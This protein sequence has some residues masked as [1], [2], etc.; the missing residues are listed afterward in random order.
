[1]G[2]V[3]LI[4]IT[5][6]ANPRL[7]LPIRALNSV[8]APLVRRLNG[9]DPDDLLDAARRR[10]GLENYGNDSFLEPYRVLLRALEEEASLSALGRIATRGLI[11]QLLSNRLLIEDLIA[12]NPEIEEEKVERPIVIAGLPR[13]GTT[14]LLN[15]LAQD[16]ELRTLPY[17]ESLEPVPSGAARGGLTDLDSRLERCRRDIDRLDRM[18]PLFRMMHEFEVDGPHEEIQL[19]A[20]QFSTQLFEA[21]YRVPSYSEWLQQSDQTVAYAYTKRVLKALQWLRG[22]TRWALK[23]P[24]HLENLGPLISVFPDAFFVQTHRDPVSITASLCTMI[25]YSRRMST[26][27]RAIDPVEIA[28]FYAA[29]IE[30]WLHDCI[31]DRHYLPEGRV[32]D[33]HFDEFMQ[34]D[35][36]MVSRVLEFAGQPVTDALLATLRRYIDDHPRARHGKI[37]Y[38][39]SALGLDRAERRRAL[40]F[41]QQ[42]FGVPSEAE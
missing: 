14:H 1:M 10:T 13:T 8:G 29:R 4:H 2:A 27:R 22:P 17:W 20:I 37:A 33:V 25:A 41:Y 23:S 28:G 3:D 5:D 6:L 35:L 24:Q 12:R 16:P 19:F 42:H 30:K 15:L 26:V 11:L 39:L 7:P 36:A 9:L 40:A 32:L 38:D 21:T 31:D 18:M 34:D